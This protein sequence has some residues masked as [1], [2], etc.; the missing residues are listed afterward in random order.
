MNYLFL[1]NPYDDQK[2]NDY[3]SDY[4]K[5]KNDLINLNKGENPGEVVELTLL[6]DK[7]VTNKKLSRF[8]ETSSKKNAKDLRCDEMVEMVKS[9]KSSSKDSLSK[10]IGLSNIE[11]L[12]DALGNPGVSIIAYF[13]SDIDNIKN[14]TH[15]KEIECKPDYLS[16]FILGMYIV[17]NAGG[18]SE[19]T[20]I[21]NV[22]RHVTL[23]GSADDIKV[24]KSSIH[25]S[26]NIFHQVV[27][28]YSPE[29]AYSVSDI[30]TAKLYE[31]YKKLMFL[32][33]SV[34]TDTKFNFVKLIL[35]HLDANHTGVNSNGFS[36]KEIYEF[37]R[38]RFRTMMTAGMLCGLDIPFDFYNAYVSDYESID[39]TIMA[40]TTSDWDLKYKD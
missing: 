28:G 1:G 12:R 32:G 4:L 14:I 16:A 9:Q 8:L 21:S 7:L 23:L 11:L 10:V 3:Y 5:I 17:N 2:C 27:S 18:S 19:V 20:D 36:Y 35:N 40:A 31:R 33:K 38:I 25:D 30:R 26:L 13:N 22:M 6:L 24:V 15:P 39:H 37:I 34:T 29:L